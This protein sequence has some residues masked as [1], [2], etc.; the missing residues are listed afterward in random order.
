MPELMKKRRTESRATEIQIKD[1]KKVLRF[2]DVPASKLRPILVSLKEYLDETL[3]WREVAKDRIKAAGGE[4]AHMV[5]TSRVMAGLS[6]VELARLLKMPQSNISH[7]ESGR[8]T[9]GKVLAKKLA[10]IFH[11]DYRVFL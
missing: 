3:P 11:V 4:T 9:V 10:K 2:T 7:V 8:R 5:R 6:Q 1:G